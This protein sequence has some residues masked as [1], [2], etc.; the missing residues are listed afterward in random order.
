MLITADALKADYAED[1]FTCEDDI[2]RNGGEMFIVDRTSMQNPLKILDIPVIK[3]WY[4]KLQTQSLQINCLQL[5]YMLH[6]FQK[7]YL[8]I[9]EVSREIL[10]NFS[11]KDKKLR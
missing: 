5:F 11:I 4:G 8:Q 10:S 9:I 3:Y 6:G 1:H 7:S 2:S